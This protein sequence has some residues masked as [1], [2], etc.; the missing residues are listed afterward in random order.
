[1]RR[2]FFAALAALIAVAACDTIEPMLP[3]GTLPLPVPPTQ[4]APK[5]APGPD[6]AFRYHAPGDLLSGSGQGAVD[7][8]IYAPGIAFP[9]RTAKAFLNSQVFSPGGMNGGPGGQCAPVNYTYPWRDTFCE[10]RSADRSSFNC[11]TRRIHQGVDIR[12]GDAATC[13]GMAGAP[14]SEHRAIEVVAA[15]TGIVSYVG[16][17]SVEI[18]A[19]PRIYRYLHMNPNAIRVRLGETVVK[20]QPI[21]FLSN[22]FGGAP[23]TLHLHFEIKQNMDGRGFTW[24]NPYMSLV[25]AYERREGRR[26]LMLPAQNQTG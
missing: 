13:R 2:A 5:P 25:D 24:V 26:G 11:P 19:G 4:P 3:P 17:I 7:S 9:I 23:T 21:G 12:A 14:S 18:R 1:M 6:A 16:E 22:W 15:D 20:G 8:T 10:S